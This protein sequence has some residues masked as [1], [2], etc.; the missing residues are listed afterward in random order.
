MKV[1]SGIRPEPGARVSARGDPAA[2]VA[3]SCAPPRRHRKPAGLACC[4]H[5]NMEARLAPREPAHAHDVNLTSRPVL[6]LPSR[7]C[8]LGARVA[9]PSPAL[10]LLPSIRGKLRSGP[11]FVPTRSPSSVRAKSYPSSLLPGRTGRRLCF[12]R[13]RQRGR[14]LGEAGRARQRGGFSGVLLSGGR[15]SSSFSPPFVRPPLAAS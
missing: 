13:P 6:L 8:L 12:V 15:A 9:T 3:I 10:S 14:P 1:L 5:T 2:A 4:V 11:L 7:E